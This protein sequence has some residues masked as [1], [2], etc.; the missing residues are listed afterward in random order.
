MDNLTKGQ[1]FGTSRNEIAVNGLTIVQSTY[2]N[3]HNCPWHYHENAYFAFTTSG[4]LVETYKR[5]EIVLRT[6]SLTYHHSQ[7]PHC[8]SHYAPYVSAL[9]VDIDTNW[10]DQCDLGK[11]RPEGL[12]ELRSPDIKIIFAR[13]LA[14]AKYGGTEKKLGMESLVISA[15]SKMLRLPD[16]TDNKPV[17]QKQ[18]KELLYAHYD[19]NMSL[20]DI[21]AQL[22]LHPVYLSQQFP[23]LFHCTLS[24]YVRRIKIEKAT[25]RLM[26]GDV[27][28]LTELAYSCGFADQSHFIRIFKKHTGLTPLA[29][30]KLI[31]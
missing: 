7:E 31:R 30:R 23:K 12:R 29:F 27:D 2:H 10:L 16:F 1:F 15:F 17:W 22:Q 19:Q 14:E 20:T 8:N 4:H 28:S 6:G 26:A 18:L 3:L 5:K 25:E 21:A 24:E 13:L 11:S 9:H